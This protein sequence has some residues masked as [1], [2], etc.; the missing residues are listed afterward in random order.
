MNGEMLLHSAVQHRGMGNF[1][2][3]VIAKPSINYPKQAVM[4]VAMTTGSPMY[5]VPFERRG[6]EGAASIYWSAL[7]FF[8]S[9]SFFLW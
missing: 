8:F 7:C 4:P 1:K 6:K 3:T 2:H 5:F 9:Y